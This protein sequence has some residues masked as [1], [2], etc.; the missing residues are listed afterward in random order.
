MYTVENSR[1][2][3]KRIDPVSG[4]TCYVLSTRVA[5]IQ[6]AFYFVNSGLSGDGRYFWFYCAFPPTPGH[7]MG[8]VDLLTDEVRVFPETFA[9]DAIFAVEPD[10][11]NVW[12]GTAQGYFIRTPHPGD[13]PLLAAPLPRL[14]RFGAAG[15]HLTF[16][17]DRREMF[18]DIQCSDRS[19]L[20]SIDIASG[21]FTE[22]FR[23]EEGVPYNH[24]QFNPVDPNLA[25]C[26][27]EYHVDK[28]TGKSFPPP[29]TED[30]IYPRLH[31]V[32]RDGVDT[33]YPPMYDVAGHEWW[34]ADGKKIYYEDGHR[35]IRWDLEKGCNELVVDG[36]RF[37][38]PDKFDATV[39]HAHC[40]ADEKY[41]TADSDYW[42][43]NCPRFWRGNASHV[44]F[45][46]T[47]TDRHVD[48]VSYNPTVPE[49][50]PERQC[51]YH[52]D[53]HPRFVLNDQWITFTTTV[54]GRVDAA[55]APVAP[56][57]RAT[58]D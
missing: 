32:T 42:L 1:H 17:R 24:A 46:N 11:G 23:T 40:S 14:G 13:K 39:W 29:R 21:T 9:G 52:I 26:A 8:V 20:G 30:G 31:T 56:L 10:S 7:C 15:T 33:M 22:W 27:H 55:I 5:P 50:T 41:F 3:T 25:L 6:Q 37:H 54:D 57:L 2:F 36:D 4:M 43:E 45:Y 12:W 48:I 16:S 18:V 58:E 51:P 28:A 34:S 38:D 53:P 19:V 35:I 47:V 44:S 49:W